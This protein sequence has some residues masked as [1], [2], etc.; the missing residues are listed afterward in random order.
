MLQWLFEIGSLSLPDAVARVRQLIHPHN[1]PSNG[2][3]NEVM[4]HEPYNDNECLGPISQ[5]MV[6]MVADRDPVLVETAPL[7]CRSGLGRGVVLPTD[8][9]RPRRLLRRC[10]SILRCNAPR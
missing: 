3:R 7:A 6:Q 2:D 4:I 1:R 8:L 10:D 5:M 9:G